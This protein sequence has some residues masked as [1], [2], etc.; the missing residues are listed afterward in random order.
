MDSFIQSLMWHRKS[1][2]FPAPQIEGEIYQVSTVSALLE[3]VYD[4]DVT[5]AQVMRHGDFGLGTFNGLDGQMIAF[6]GACFQIKADG[7]VRRASP[8]S[9]TPFAV[10]TF[11]RPDMSVTL[12]GP[13]KFREFQE[14]LDSELKAPNEFYAIYAE[15]TCE[16]LRVRTMAKQSEPYLPMAEVVRSQPEYGHKNV[17][18]VMVGFRFPK[19]TEQLDLPGYQLLFIDEERNFGGHVVD[20]VVKDIAVDVDHTSRFH[21][22]LPAQE[23]LPV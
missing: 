12:D 1:E 20:A 6:H 23:D 3:G 9:K 15:V 11:F 4:G 5:Y 19:F 7:K 16:R 17:K 22:V 10:V 21:L 8:N 18:G 2:L 14:T 13:L